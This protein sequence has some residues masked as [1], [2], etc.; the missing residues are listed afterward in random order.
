LISSN[1]K[2][3]ENLAVKGERLHG[4]GLPYK[5]NRALRDW[6]ITGKEKGTI[7]KDQDKQIREQQLKA[8]K[9]LRYFG[10]EPS[11]GHYY[12]RRMAV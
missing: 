3:L 6:L 7:Y 5:I 8:I 11:D 10:V 12:V 4:T 9:A 2:N 1:S